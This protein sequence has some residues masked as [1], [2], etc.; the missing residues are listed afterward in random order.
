MIQDYFK[1]T[2]IGRASLTIGLN[3]ILDSAYVIIVNI[4]GLAYGLSE[5]GSKVDLSANSFTTCVY[6]NTVTTSAIFLAQCGQR[7]K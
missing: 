1:I 5:F 2:N 7:S 4:D 6:P 3:S